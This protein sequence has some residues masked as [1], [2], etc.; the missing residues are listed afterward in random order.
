MFSVLG[1]ETPDK[2]SKDL[3]KPSLPT[4]GLQGLDPKYGPGHIP[5]CL[6]HLQSFGTIG[7]RTT[8]PDPQVAL[9]PAAGGLGEVRHLI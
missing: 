5:K 7:P 9:G 6:T 1:P 4:L 3:Q 8:A 2:G